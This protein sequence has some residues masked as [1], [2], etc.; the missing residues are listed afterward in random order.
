MMIYYMRNLSIIFNEL[1]LYWFIRRETVLIKIISRI[2]L[3][4]LLDIFG[5]MKVSSMGKVCVCLNVKV[6]SPF[7]CEEGDRQQ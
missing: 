2:K 3:E 7:K 4:M 5:D 1:P 6:K